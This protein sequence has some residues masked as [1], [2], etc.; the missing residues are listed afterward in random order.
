[1]YSTNAATSAM[2]RALDRYAPHPARISRNPRYIGLRVTRYT[3]EI[4]SDDEDSGFIGFTV[5]LARLKETTPRMATS[6]PTRPRPPATANRPGRVKPDL[7]TAQAAAPMS[8]PVKIPTA[9]GGTLRSRAWPGMRRSII[10]NPWKLFLYRS[11]ANLRRR[12]AFP[13]TDTEL[14]LIAAAA[15]IGLRRIRT[16]G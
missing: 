9:T 1:M 8:A 4:T 10:G 11:S 5:V 2:E 15:I 6:A 3:P 12:K 13:M 14:R 7:G 16:I